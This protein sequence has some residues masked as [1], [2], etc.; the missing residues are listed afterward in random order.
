[1]ARGR[2]AGQVVRLDATRVSGLPLIKGPA[3]GAISAPGPAWSAHPTSHSRLTD[4]SYRGGLQPPAGT[5]H[6]ALT[7][8]YVLRRAVRMNRVSLA[9]KGSGVRIP[10]APPPPAAAAAPVSAGQLAWPH[11]R[12]DQW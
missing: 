5:A 11:R 8:A 12:I 2:W 10:S 1:M 6:Q 9:V 3:G 4:C 7:C